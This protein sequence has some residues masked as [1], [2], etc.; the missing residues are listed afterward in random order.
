[1]KKTSFRDIKPLIFSSTNVAQ[2]FG[3]GKPS[4]RVACHRNVH[5]KTLVRLKRDMYV[6]RDR[7]ERSGTEEFYL[8]ANLLQV[9]S[10]VSFTT[11]LSYY[12]VTTQVQR[13]FV[14]SAALVRTKE[15]KVGDIEFKYMK[16]K[17]ELYQGFVKKNGYFIATLEK[18]FLDSLYL[19]SLNRYRLDLSAID[20][21]KLNKKELRRLFKIYPAKVREWIKK[22]VRF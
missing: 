16:L 7:W 1:M 13:D 2:A 18:A 9:P 20:R 6:L 10:Y 4:A 17:Q 8:A 5:N 19:M 14:E 21:D 15:I 3:I 11:A 22:N 12:G